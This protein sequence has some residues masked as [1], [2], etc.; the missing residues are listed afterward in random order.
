MAL[1]LALAV[2]IPLAVRAALCEGSRL[3]R[4]AHVGMCVIYGVPEFM[5]AAILVVI[6][7]R[8]GSETSGSVAFGSGGRVIEL[9]GNLLLPA[10]TLA[11][12][13]GAMLY[14]FLRESV[15]RAVKSDFVTAMRGLGMPEAEL[16]RRVLRNGL[17]PVVTLLGSML[18]TLV[19]GTVVVEQI[20][21]LR[22]L[23]Q[24]TWHAAKHREIE[25]IMALTMMV[26]VATLIS[27][28]LSDIAQRVV[29]PRVELR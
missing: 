2:A 22:G 9:L 11:L 6:S 29:D 8:L 23:G 10:M 18:P 25:L 3:D 16:R 27:V 14:R 19:G 7:G 1:L 4:T 17:S 21:D 5:I 12:G 20:F 28:L 15:G 24:L 13:Y 26:S